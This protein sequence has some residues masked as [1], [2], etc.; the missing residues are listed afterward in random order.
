ML[1]EASE[2]AL[3]MKAETFE[4]GQNIIGDKEDDNK[5]CSITQVVGGSQKHCCH[6]TQSNSLGRKCQHSQDLCCGLGTAVLMEANGFLLKPG[7][8]K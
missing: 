6:C 8:A 7:T 2:Q 4:A 5:S 3:T 1:L